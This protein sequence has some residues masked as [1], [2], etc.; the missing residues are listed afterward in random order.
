MFYFVV[1]IL[2]DPTWRWGVKAPA[3]PYEKYP[4]M[5]AKFRQKQHAE[6]FMR[7]CNLD[8][9]APNTARTAA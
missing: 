4:P 7:Q 2:N 1:P 6:L 3:L 5:V 9:I 8:V